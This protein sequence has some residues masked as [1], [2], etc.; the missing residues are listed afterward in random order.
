MPRIPI[1]T[2]LVGCCH[3]GKSARVEREPTNDEPGGVLPEGWYL[4]RRSNWVSF[5]DFC[6]LECAQALLA[7][8]E[9]Q[10]ILERS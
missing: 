8:H 4:I 6:S 3:C 9:E 10:C 7:E 2:V 1:P 5:A